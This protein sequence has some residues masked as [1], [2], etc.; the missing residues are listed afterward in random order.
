VVGIESHKSKRFNSEYEIFVDL[1]CENENI[2]ELAKSL[3]RQLSYV[4]IDSGDFS[5]LQS[6]LN[7]EKIPDDVFVETEN[8]EPKFNIDYDLTENNV[9]ERADGATE[10][11]SMTCIHRSYS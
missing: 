2:P 6:S 9:I 8:K 3:Q 4:R 5:K 11:I 7:K 1:E 10:R